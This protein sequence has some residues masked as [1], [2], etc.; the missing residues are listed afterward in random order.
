MARRGRRQKAEIWI[1]LLAIVCAIILG[2]GYFWL[3]GQPLGER[4]YTVTVILEDAGGLERGDRVHMSGVE[5]GVVRSVRLEAADRI[6]VQLWLQRDL[7]IPQD[8]RALL[9]AVGV[10]G[11]VIVTLEPGDSDT[12]ASRGDTLAV[13]RAPSL[14][15]L[16]GDLGEQAEALLLKVDRLLADS[17]ID[18]VH[19]SVAALPGTVRGLEQLVRESSDEF[20]ALSQSLR[21]T[22]ETL[23]G[24]LEDAEIEGLVADMRELA[25]TASETAASL[26]QSAESLRS[27]ADKID[28][29]EGTLGL[30]V[31]DP[32]LYEDLRAAAQN[33]ATLTRD[34]RENPARY[35]KVSVF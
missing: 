18:Q 9:Q 12:V 4:G 1:G 6:V 24:T 15:D 23:Q 7:R 3:T 2:W 25:T 35:L 28:R 20:A 16:A 8:T 10:F 27:I 5:V 21:A 33:A 29:G 22:A 19:G 30:L 13:G 17:T 31:N 34:I 32:G 11:D 26:S 14:M